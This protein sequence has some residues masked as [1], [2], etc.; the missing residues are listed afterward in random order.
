MKRIGILTFH[1]S[2]NYGAFMQCYALSKEI[3]KRTGIMP[4]VVD[5]EYKWKSEH[6]AEPLNNFFL[7]KE[8]L[9]Q[10]NRFRQD[11]SLL[12]LSSESFI[13]DDT[14]E[15]LT[16]LQKNYDILIVGSDAVW[17][18]NKMTTIDNP[19]WLFGNNLDCIKMSFAASAYSLDFQSVSDADKM[20]IKE[21]VN[22]FDYVGIRDQETLNF[23]QQILPD[24]KLHR[25]CDPT[26]LLEGGDKSIAAT[27]I[28]R[29]KLKPNKKIAT[30]MIAG[31]DYVPSI[32]K[33]IEKEYQP[34]Q[35][36]KRNRL[37]DKYIPGSKGKM[38]YDIS[39]F[40]WY[41]F[42]AASSLNISNY[43]HG[44]IVALR[45]LVPS[46]AFDNTNFS[47]E[48]TSKIKQF[49]KDLDLMD[50]YFHYASMN[51][52]DVTRL[53]EQIEIIKQD[54]EAIKHKIAKNIEIEKLKANSF[55]EQLEKYL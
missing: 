15:L 30:F 17:A 41:N 40:E 19:Y 29:H 53:Y 39:P 23:I 20:Y 47:Y 13:T 11:L 33:K 5:F 3:F 35:L 1:R 9:L 37:K 16:F 12:N 32:I 51:D 27:V 44:T 34:I 43:F 36:Y 2:I 10:Y 48:Y 54:P 24:K 31:N 38:I 49:M 21:H 50:F 8:Y 46:I 25:N 26:V 4:D 22:S 7:G 28:K 55:F 6:H 52:K 14:N 45:S 18:Y 42:Y